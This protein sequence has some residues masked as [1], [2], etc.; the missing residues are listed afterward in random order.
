MKIGYIQVR[1]ICSELLIRWY[2]CVSGTYAIIR[3]ELQI[4][5]KETLMSALN[6]PK[7]H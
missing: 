3:H 2:V 7:G 1:L 4:T 5:I 6:F